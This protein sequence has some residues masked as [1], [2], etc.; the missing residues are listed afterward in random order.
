METNIYGAM[1]ELAD[2]YQSI[3][4][5]IDIHYMFEIHWL[6]FFEEELEFNFFWKLD[7]NFSFKNESRAT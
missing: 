6:S 3:T 1:V 7:S 4:S 2:F 5:C